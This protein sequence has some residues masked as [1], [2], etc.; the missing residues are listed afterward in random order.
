MDDAV[1]TFGALLVLLAAVIAYRVIVWAVFTRAKRE[2][3][4]EHYRNI[5]REKHD[6]EDRRWRGGA[7]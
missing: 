5:R 4:Q 1:K 7:R 3:K 6:N 2:W